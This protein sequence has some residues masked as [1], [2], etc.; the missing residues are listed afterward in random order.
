[1]IDETLRGRRVPPTEMEIAHDAVAVAYS[2]VQRHLSSIVNVNVPG[3]S[4]AGGVN[5]IAALARALARILGPDGSQLSREAAVSAG[6]T[7]SALLGIGATPAT[8]ACALAD[9]FFPRREGNEETLTSGAWRVTNG[10]GA[11]PIDSL[12]VLAAAS[13]DDVLAGFESTKAA[14]KSTQAPFKDFP[15]LAS[16]FSAFGTLSA[17]RGALTAAGPEA[18][19]LA[20]VRPGGNGN[21]AGEWAFLVDGAIPKICAWMEHPVDQHFKFHASA[22]LKSALARAKTCVVAGGDESSFAMPPALVD[23]VLTALWA[24]WEDPLTQTVKEV[25][26]AFEALTDLFS[27]SNGFLERV[28]SRLLERGVSTKGRYVP[29]AALVPKLGAR[30]LLDIRPNLLEESLDAMRDDSVCCAAG[31]LIKELSA[32]LLDEMEEEERNLAAA[33]VGIEPGTPERPSGERWVI[34]NGSGKRGGVDKGRGRGRD[35]VCIREEC[36]AAVAAWRRWWIPPTLAALLKPGRE[37]AGCAQYALPHLMRQDAASIVFLLEGLKNKKK[38]K[39]RTDDASE[40]DG[41]EGDEAASG[42]EEEARREEALRAAGVG[43]TTLKLPIEGDEIDDKDSRGDDTDDDTDD[44][45]GLDD[46]RRS[47][48]LVALLKRARAASLLDADTGVAFVCE[49]VSRAAAAGVSSQLFPDEKNPPSKKDPS[50]LDEESDVSRAFIDGK[51]PVDEAALARATVCRDRGVRKE[52]LEL[53]CV[54]GKRSSAPGATELRLLRRALPAAMRG[55]SA[56]FRNALGT[57]IRALLAR[58]KTCQT[59]AAAALR[60]AARLGPKTTTGSEKRADLDLDLEKR[61]GAAERCA[62]FT[63]WLVRLAL[64]SAYPGA[65]YERKYMA[66]DVLNAV[67]ETWGVGRVSDDDGRFQKRP[68]DS[69]FDSRA[70]RLER[71]PYRVCLGADVTTALL[72]ALVDSWDKLRVA[73]FTLLAR[74][75]SPLAGVTSA[76]EFGARARWALRLLRSPRVRESDAAALLMRLLLRKYAVDLGW[77]VTLSPEPKATATNATNRTKGETA[78]RLLGER[79]DPSPSAPGC[80]LFI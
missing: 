34:G 79:L 77:D 18:L 50:E 27:K 72:G 13:A 80:F 30:K 74:H 40:K 14:F 12:R 48:A 6:V 73:A 61:A 17:V 1:M 25:Q 60:T 10:V 47:A 16:S 51:Y 22:A 59:R 21:T 35:E 4:P 66:L 8:H 3:S 71:S 42:S 36:G 55:E 23:R 45:D 9:A 54:D 19:S 20:L 11:P 28:A 57:M 62:E 53:L 37:R 63:E 31:T 39:K 26:G 41:N 52:A 65:P 68:T 67:A 29:L 7:F 78:A 44:D 76:E 56:A 69:D 2:L 38:K 49:S 24:N 75:P 5:A 58:I 32:K 15:S 33:A 64:A 43:V 46:E 70:E